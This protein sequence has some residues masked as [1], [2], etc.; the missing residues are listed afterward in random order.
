[1]SS[2]PPCGGL[3]GTYQEIERG[4]YEYG[5]E[6]GGELKNFFLVA[7]GPEKD[8]EDLMLRM[9]KATSRRLSIVGFVLRHLAGDS[10]YTYRFCPADHRQLRN[11]RSSNVNY[12]Q[13]C[14][15]PN[16]TGDVNHEYEQ[17]IAPE[18]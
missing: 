4:E 18:Y 11:V 6:E 15:H 2:I 16:A 5:A 8:H 3:G 1:M 14:L 17:N 9:E 12:V 10:Q 13:R 7:D